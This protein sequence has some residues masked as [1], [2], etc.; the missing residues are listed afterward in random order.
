MPGK[1]TLASAP[2]DVLCSVQQVDVSRGCG[3]LPIASP[4]G[5]AAGLLIAGPSVPMFQTL[6]LSPNLV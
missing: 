3:I 6:L 1:E 5:L 2:G 4:R